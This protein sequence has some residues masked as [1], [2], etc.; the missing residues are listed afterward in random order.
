MTPQ[1]LS[2]LNIL[3]TVVIFTL[4]FSVPILVMIML[5]E[6]YDKYKKERGGCVRRA[7]IGPPY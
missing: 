4:V 2:A 7:R 5:L 3:F 1:I 6:K